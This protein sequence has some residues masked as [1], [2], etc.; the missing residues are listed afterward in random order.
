MKLFCKHQN[1]IW[2]KKANDSLVY[3]ILK[4]NFSSN[5]LKIQNSKNDNIENIENKEEEYSY[6]TDKEY[7]EYWMGIHENGPSDILV[8][9]KIVPLKDYIKEINGNE[10]QNNLPF[11]FKVLSIE[12]PL[13]IQV[14]PDK[15]FAQYLHNKLPNKYKDCNNKPEMA[16]S[17]SDDFSLLYGIKKLEEFKNINSKLIETLEKY[18]NISGLYKCDE[19]NYFKLISYVLGLKDQNTLK[20]ILDEIMNIEFENDDNEFHVIRLLFDNFKY[21]LGVIFSIFMNYLKLKK[22]ECIFIGDNIPHSYIYGDIMEIMVNSDFVIRLGCTNKEVDTES[23][24]E[25]LK[26]SFNNLMETNNFIN[27]IEKVND[28]TFLYGLKNFDQ[29]YVHFIRGNLIDNN[30]ND[31]EFLVSENSIMFIYSCSCNL[32]EKTIIQVDE[33]EINIK[34]YDT[35]FLKKDNKIKIRKKYLHDFEA[36]IGSGRN[37]Y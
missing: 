24:S 4:E 21:D 15:L 30:S 31:F 36:F 8:K 35:L 14:H 23:F 25:I 20:N 18:S 11:L 3:K 22:Y 32:N 12:K 19:E 7:A 27:C 17:L 9:E 2:G 29:F 28:G 16:I 5:N 10:C 33:N 37:S 1:Y 34:L 26:S 6:L 13:S